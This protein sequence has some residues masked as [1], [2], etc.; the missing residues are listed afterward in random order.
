MPQPADARRAR[1]LLHRTARAYFVEFDR[2]VNDEAD[3][4]EERRLS[5]AE[6][7]LENAARLFAE[8]HPITPPG[9]SREAVRAFLA[10][11]PALG[12]VDVQK[13]AMRLHA[14]GL[15]APVRP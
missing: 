3:W 14:R 7:N 1:H 2:F 5:R 15:R 4:K 8:K 13:L 11:D 6:R 9:D 12:G 10:S